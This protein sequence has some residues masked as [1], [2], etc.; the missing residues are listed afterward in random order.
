MSNAVL[1]M[2]TSLDGFVAGPNAGRARGAAQRRPLPRRTL[3]DRGDRAVDISA[4]LEW[5]AVI[6]RPAPRRLRSERQPSG[7]DCGGSHRKDDHLDPHH[8]RWR[9]RPLALGLG[10]PGGRGRTAQVRSAPGRGRV[11][12]RAQGLLGPRQRLAHHH[13]RHRLRRAGEQHLQVRRLPDP[14]RTPRVERVVDQGRPRRE[15]DQPQASAPREPDLLRLWRA[16]LR[17][18]ASWR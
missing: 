12:A 2:S 3:L 16:G 9:H 15:R 8:H 10:H 11:P 4:G 18:P 17:A 7:P 14:G 1:Y 13:R 6:G 5:P